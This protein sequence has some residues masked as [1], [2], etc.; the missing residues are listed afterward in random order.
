MQQNLQKMTPRL[1]SLC[2]VC[3]H[4]SIRLKGLNTFELGL[5]RHSRFR[6][7]DMFVFRVR[8]VGAMA[9]LGT[10]EQFQALSLELGMDAT[11]KA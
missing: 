9:V 6:K 8:Q 2:K 3:N 4:Q 11:A 1:K 7:V 5:T 10:A